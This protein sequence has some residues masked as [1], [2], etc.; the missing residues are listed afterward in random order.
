MGLSVVG[1]AWGLHRVRIKRLEENERKLVELVDTRTS[2]LRQSRDELEV[3]VADRTL[4]LSRLNVSLEAEV[5]TRTIAEQRAAAASQAKTE[6]LTNMS[7]EIRTPIN[8]IMGMTDLT[9]TTEVSDEQREYLE[10]VKASADALLLV[11]NDIMDFSQMES[12]RLTLEEAPFQLFS[13]IAELEAL[14]TLRATQKGLSITFSTAP[15]VPDH[16]KGDRGRV[17]QVLLNLLDNGIKFTHV[18]SVSL[19]VAAEQISGSEALLH[20]SVTD[21]GVGIAPDK[22]ETIFEAFSQADTSLT[23]RFGGTGLGLTISSRLAH[24]MRGELWVESELDA[25]STFHFT[26]LFGMAPEANALPHLAEARRF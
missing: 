14:L 3:R 15:G 2:E 9:L 5:A 4:D 13:V 17:R 6:F 8:G 11:V 24:L 12:Q 26:A 25:G 23:R 1:G 7:H 20:F 19:R 21:T 10:I 22:Q 18:G 16:V